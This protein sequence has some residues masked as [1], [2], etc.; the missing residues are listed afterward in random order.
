MEWEFSFIAVLILLFYCC[1]GFT[2]VLVLL[3]LLLLLIPEELLPFPEGKEQP[4]PQTKHSYAT[5]CRYGGKDEEVVSNWVDI[6]A[7]AVR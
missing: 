4:Q 5:K 1:I 2:A 7:S 3:M 6:L